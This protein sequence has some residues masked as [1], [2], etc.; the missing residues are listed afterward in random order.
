MFSASSVIPKCLPSSSKPFKLTFGVGRPDELPT[1]EDVSK[2]YIDL[3]EDTAMVK[4]STF[5][6]AFEIVAIFCIIIVTFVLF[7]NLISER[8]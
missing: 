3:I 2:V 5:Q 8:W 4:M 7:P 6:Y 1:A